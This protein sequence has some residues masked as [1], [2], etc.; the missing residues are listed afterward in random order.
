M[1]MNPPP[2]D[3]SFFSAL[4]GSMDDV[5]I[6]GGGDG[7]PLKN[8]NASFDRSHAAKAES[9]AQAIRSSMSMDRES[10]SC[11]QLDMDSDQEAFWG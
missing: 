7:A 5:S 9:W 4:F 2:L 10:L 1:P 3:S 11:V 8:L 6:G